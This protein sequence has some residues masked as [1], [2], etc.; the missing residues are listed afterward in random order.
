MSDGAFRIL[1][2]EGR[3]SWTFNSVSYSSLDFT[4]G[5]SLDLTGHNCDRNLAAR[6]RRHRAASHLHIHGLC[7]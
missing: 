1:V 6:S 7:R 2:R 4:D 5:Y 3:V